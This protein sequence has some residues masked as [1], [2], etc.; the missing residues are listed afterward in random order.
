MGVPWTEEDMA[1]AI[2]AYQEGIKRGN[3]TLKLGTVASA[4]GVPYNT[5]KYRLTGK[6][7]IGIML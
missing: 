5:L 3:K 1:N 7:V 2:K 6:V 4:H